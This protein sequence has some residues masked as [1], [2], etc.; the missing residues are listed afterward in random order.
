M[1]LTTPTACW[2]LIYH[3]INKV[4]SDFIPKFLHIDVEI[5]PR[6]TVLMLVYDESQQNLDIENE[7][8]RIDRIVLPV[9]FHI[10]ASTFPLP[11][12]SRFSLEIQNLTFFFFSNIPS[13]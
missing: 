4:L 5:L 12:S 9:G 10:H 7:K 13:A 1:S 6:H 8:S 3:R 11:K 2:N